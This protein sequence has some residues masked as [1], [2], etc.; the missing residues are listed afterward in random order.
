MQISGHSWRLKTVCE[1]WHNLGFNS[2]P[3]TAHT[4]LSHYALYQSA[5]T[6]MNMNEIWNGTMKMNNIKLYW[7]II[8]AISSC[9]IYKGQCLPTFPIEILR[10]I[11]DRYL[12]N[13]QIASGRFCATPAE[14]KYFGFCGLIWR[15]TPI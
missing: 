6:P 3:Y 14:T 7:Y 5:F 12:S 10:L 1:I 13:L 4:D 15:T 8:G 11:S 9:D 2:R